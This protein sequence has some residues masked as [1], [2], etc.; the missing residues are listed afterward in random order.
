M[1]MCITMLKVINSKRYNQLAVELLKK[2]FNG[3]YKP[4]AKLPSTRELAK[5]AENQIY[6]DEINSYGNSFEKL[7]ESTRICSSN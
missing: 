3:Y 5:Q 1:E 6:Q 7:G 4:G 2:I